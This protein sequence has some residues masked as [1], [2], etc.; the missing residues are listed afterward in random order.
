[1]VGTS[2]I[3]EAS[4]DDLAHPIADSL[5]DLVDGL[6]GHVEL[7]GHGLNRLSPEQLLEDRHASRLEGGADKSHGGT[8]VMTDPFFI[9]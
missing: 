1:M 5:L 8:E 6:L 9:P 4:R 3:G 2:F 7:A